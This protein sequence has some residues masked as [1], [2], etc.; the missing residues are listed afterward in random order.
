MIDGLKLVSTE[1]P[2]K[3]IKITEAKYVAKKSCYW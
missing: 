3:Q 1:K 2:L